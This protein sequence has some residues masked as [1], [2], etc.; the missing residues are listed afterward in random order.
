RS[1][2]SWKYRKESSMKTVKILGALALIVV[3]GLAIYVFSQTNGE[4]KSVTGCLQ[5]GD[6]ANEYSI[7]DASG[8][9]YGLRSSKVKLADHLGH[10]VTITGHLK[11]ESDEDEEREEK[12]SK[13]KEAGDIQVTK[14][15]M[16]SASCQ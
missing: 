5:K 13:Q 7:T 10:K 9:M 4:T 12:G 8:K 11:R 2:Y 1:G 6:E 16:A 3:F 14:L 15:T